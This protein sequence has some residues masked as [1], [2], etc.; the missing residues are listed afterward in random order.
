MSAGPASTPYD[1]VDL[2]EGAVHLWAGGPG[3][4][5]SLAMR[6]EVAYASA[7]MGRVV[8]AAAFA[9]AVRDGA[10]DP[11]ERTRLER[12]RDTGDRGVLA[13]LGGGLNPTWHDLLVIM[14]TVEDAE[15]AIR[16]CARL[17]PAAVGDA[18]QALGL[19]PGAMD[20][21]PAAPPRL[22]ARVAA[23]AMSR[24]AVHAGEDGLA[25]LLPHMRSVR[26]RWRVRTRL[27]EEWVVATAGSRGRG[28]VEEVALWR[29]AEG[30]ASAA[31]A[32]TGV[33]DP[34][35]AEYVM[36]DGFRR[37]VEHIGAPVAD[38]EGG[39]GR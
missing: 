12:S 15:A 16:L 33:D 23:A 38:A 39:A 9:R 5:R 35:R 3:G 1:G 25:M 29:T 37:V 31:V 27:D 13:T 6:P 11:G 24:L 17:G 2:V 21:Y 32:M 30:W 19:P 7:G 36:G 8:V 22:G 20:A 26:Y 28:S 10:I 18:A 14:L 34:W 4:S